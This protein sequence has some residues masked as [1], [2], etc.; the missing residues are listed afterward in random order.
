MDELIT[1]QFNIIKRILEPLIRN[2]QA[3]DK[4]LRETQIRQ[5]EIKNFTEKT[6]ATKISQAYKSFK[7]Y[8]SVML[9]KNEAATSIAQAY[10]SKLWLVD[11]NKSISDALCELSSTQ[12]VYRRNIN[13]ILTRRGAEKK[14]K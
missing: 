13:E 10:K 6:A 7:S 9:R 4:L 11:E 2:K 8:K 3:R 1:K 14:T 5:E 12:D